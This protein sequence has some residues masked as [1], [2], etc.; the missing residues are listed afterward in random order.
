MI[1]TA[2]SCPNEQGVMSKGLTPGTVSRLINKGGNV[3]LFFAYINVHRSQYFLTFIFY[4][5]RHSI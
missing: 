1:T 2:Y 5:I 4:K 3:K